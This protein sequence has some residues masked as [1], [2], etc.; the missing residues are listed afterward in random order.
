MYYSQAEFVASCKSDRTGKWLTSNPACLGLQKRIKAQ[1]KLLRW[2]GVQIR[3]GAS[4]TPERRGQRSLSCPGHCLPFADT[5]RTCILAAATDANQN[6]CVHLTICPPTCI[7]SCSKQN[8]MYTCPHTYML[9]VV[10]DAKQPVYVSSHI[11]A[12]SCNRCK[13]ALIHALL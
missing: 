5:P 6:Q 13:T 8:S 1:A 10:K 7:G 2:L 9:A 12:G 11:Y 4:Y 3:V